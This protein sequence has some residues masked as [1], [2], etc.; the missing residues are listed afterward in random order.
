MYESETWKQTKKRARSAGIRQQMPPTDPTNQIAR[1]N[2]QLRTVEIEQASH[3]SQA[4]SR[5]ENGIGYDTF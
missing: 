1:K 4:P 2:Q 3:P 5:N